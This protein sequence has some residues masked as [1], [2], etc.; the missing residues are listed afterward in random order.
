[1][2]DLFMKRSPEWLAL[3]RGKERPLLL[4]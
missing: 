3:E 4:V 2:S 1:M